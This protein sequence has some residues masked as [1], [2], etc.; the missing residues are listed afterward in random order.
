[1][2]EIKITSCTRGW[3]LGRATECDD[4]VDRHD[5]RKNQVLY[6]MKV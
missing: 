2:Y 4:Q 1:M 3:T 5:T 6:Y